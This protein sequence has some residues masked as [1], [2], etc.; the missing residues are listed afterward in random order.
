MG[1][2][3][4]LCH[5]KW[6]CKYHVVWIPKYRRK[7]LYGQIRK[8]LGELF[9]DLAAKKESKILEGY[10]QAD[11]VHVLLSIPP[12]YS[13]AIKASGFAGGDSLAEESGLRHDTKKKNAI[14]VKSKLLHEG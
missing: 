14:V 12:K 13:V 6:E 8:Y 3:Q 9:H 2:I 7:V 10:L 5:T 4:S 1:N 11:L